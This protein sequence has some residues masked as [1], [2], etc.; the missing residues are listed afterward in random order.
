[1]KLISSGRVSMS[2][3]VQCA[4]LAVHFHLNTVEELKQ[5]FRIVRNKVDQSDFQCL[6]C[7]DRHGIFHHGFSKGNHLCS[8]RHSTN[9][10]APW[11]SDLP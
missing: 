2:V 4:G 3:C 1:M 8:A 9:S 5:V 10:S 7:S 11:L 6:V